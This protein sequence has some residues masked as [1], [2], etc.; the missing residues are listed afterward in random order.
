M[1]LEPGMEAGEESFDLASAALDER[2]VHA[3]LGHAAT[4][5]RVLGIPVALDDD[6]V[7]DV[8]ERPRGAHAGDAAA[9]DQ[10]SPPRGSRRCHWLGAVA[11]VKTRMASTPVGTPA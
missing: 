5:C 3:T 8:R 10:G 7:V 11:S 4:L 6:F 9:D 1:L 2:V